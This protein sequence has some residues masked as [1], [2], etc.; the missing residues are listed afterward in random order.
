MTN[1]ERWERVLSATKV[2]TDKTETV[3]NFIKSFQAEFKNGPI[4]EEVVEMLGI[5]YNRPPLTRRVG[6]WYLKKLENQGRI[7]LGYNMFGAKKNRIPGRIIVLDEGTTGGVPEGNTTEF[8]CD[9]VGEESFLRDSGGA[10]IGYVV[11]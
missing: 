10:I 9:L 5:K 8:D 2:G 4:L 7:E 1:T 3:L 11:E 6:A